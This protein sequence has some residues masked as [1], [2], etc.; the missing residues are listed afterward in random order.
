MYIKK[1]CFMGKFGFYMRI[2]FPKLCGNAF[3]YVSRKNSNH[4]IKKYINSKKEFY[5]LFVSIE[6]VNRCNGTCPFC[7]CNI[8]DDKRLYKEMNDEIFKKIINDLKEIHYKNT[9][10]LLANNEIFLDKKILDRLRFA[11]KELPEAHMKIITNG[12]LLTTSIFQKLNDEH[13][14]DELI[15]NNYNTTMALNTP[16]KKLYDKYKNIDLNIDTI[17]NLRY[18]DEILSNRAGSS[19]NKKASK[20][21]KDYCA[22]PYTDININ[23]EGNFLICCCDAIERTNLGNIKNNTLIEI[24]NN[25][26]YQSIRNNMRQGRYNNKFCQLCDFN[27]VG[28]RKQLIKKELKNAGKNYERN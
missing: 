1:K 6:T 10:M 3:L 11:R 18:S 13:L 28:T 21:I 2:K 12:K 24:F 16:I 26:K 4:L 25:K 9:L 22:L 17:I 19:P 23:P 7:P 5:P 27:D 15:I 20:I 8:K 14:V